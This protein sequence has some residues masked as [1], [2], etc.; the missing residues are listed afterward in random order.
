MYPSVL[1]AAVL[2]KTGQALGL[3]HDIVMPKPG[4]GQLLVKNKK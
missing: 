3:V 1:S 4:I 2:I